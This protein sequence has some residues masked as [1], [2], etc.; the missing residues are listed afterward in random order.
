MMSGFEKPE[1]CI[2]AIMCGYVDHELYPDY[3]EPPM[4]SRYPYTGMG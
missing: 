2:A 4:L 1:D 3:L